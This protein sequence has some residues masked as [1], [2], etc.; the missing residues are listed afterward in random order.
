MKKQILS[1][2]KSANFSDDF[3]NYVKKEFPIDYKKQFEN[4]YE[5]KIDKNP[6][7]NLNAKERLFESLAQLLDLQAYYEKRAIDLKHMYN[8]IYDLSYRL[9]RYFNEFGLYGLSDRDLRWLI[10]L[11][12][13]EIFDLGSLRFQ[14][15][16]FSNSEIERE[17]YDF[18]PLD[19]KWKKRFPEGT[20]VITIHI[21]KDTDLS[22][23]KITQSLDLAKEFFAKYF[24]E[25]DYEVFVCRTWLIY[26]KTRDILSEDSNIAEFS[27][28][29]E[30]IATNQNTKQALDR[31]YGTSDLTL[32]EKMDK[33]SS[34]QK[35]A[36]KHLDKLGVAAG[37]IYK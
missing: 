2:L 36:Y 37:I 26:P 22:K 35:T 21:L 25:H 8:S 10:P 34:L 12:K 31:I 24:S 6:L 16:R 18:M 19:D 20:P 17:G 5:E 30:I 14:R 27:K 32:I 23:D 9:E 3:I 15:F 33:N 29:F 7:L 13:A 4:P 28:L 1:I 11:F